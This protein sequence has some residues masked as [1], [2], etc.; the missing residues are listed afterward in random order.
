MKDDAR[1]LIV[2]DVHGCLDELKALLAKV[3]FERGRDR[4]V[5]VGDLLGKGPSGAEV[6]RY[7]RK[8]GHL[9]VRGNHDER[10]IAWHRGDD[11]RPLSK[12]HSRDAA[13]LSA[14]DWAWLEARPLVLPLDELGV[15][16]VHGGL[17]PGTPLEQQVP[18]TVLNLRSFRADG[19]PSNRI[20]DGEPWA[21]AW[22]GPELVVFGHDAVRGL[23]RWPFA[24]GL[25]TGC[26]YGGALTG[27]LLPEHRFVSVRARR[28][29]AA[30]EGS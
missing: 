23:Q 28:P 13:R 26:V 9:A 20:D 10:V 27:L 1:T 17:V 12:V 30:R 3:G 8:R 18:R 15:L 6:V 25:D 22:P 29:Y 14:R 24:I 2:G 5:S 7:F 21:K 16:V 19:S 4:L 11:A